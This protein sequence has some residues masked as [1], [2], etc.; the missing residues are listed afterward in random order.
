[1]NSKE[2]H[3][4]LPPLPLNI[5]SPC[6][7]QAMPKDLAVATRASMRCCVLLS[8]TSAIVRIAA[9]F[10]KMMA[11]RMFLYRLE[12]LSRQSPIS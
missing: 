8:M 10:V 12:N 11:L 9:D 7:P 6:H 1:M 3:V 4:K 2:V 5:R